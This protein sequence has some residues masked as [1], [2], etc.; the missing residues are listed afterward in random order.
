MYLHVD[1]HGGC[2]DVFKD[3]GAVSGVVAVEPGAVCQAISF[4]SFSLLVGTVYEVRAAES[5]HSTMMILT[6][7]ILFLPNLQIAII[8]SLP[9]SP[10]HIP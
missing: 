7:L 2:F 1:L 4:I 8:K 6:W 9:T 3:V 10:P 5:P